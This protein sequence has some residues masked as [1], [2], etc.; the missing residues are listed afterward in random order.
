MHPWHRSPDVLPM[1][2][3]FQSTALCHTNMT[4]HATTAVAAPI[5]PP[6][7]CNRGEVRYGSIWGL[8]YEVPQSQLYCLCINLALCS[9]AVQCICRVIR[10]RSMTMKAHIL[11]NFWTSTHRGEAS[12]FPPWRRHWA[13]PSSQNRQIIAGARQVSLV[14]GK[15]ETGT[16]H[17]VTILYMHVSVKDQRRHFTVLR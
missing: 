5:A 15:Q 8:E 12:P 10:R 1:E 14:G 11:H 7:F 2:D 9:T 3:R 13:A 4:V 16:L 6:G 17:F